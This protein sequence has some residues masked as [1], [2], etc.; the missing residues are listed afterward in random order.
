MS[1][2]LNGKTYFWV[3]TICVDEI[4]YDVY[5]DEYGNTYYQVSDTL[6]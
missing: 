6:Y 3:D 4:I 2:K 1:V 5:E